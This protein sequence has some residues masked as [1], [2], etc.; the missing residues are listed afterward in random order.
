MCPAARLPIKS[1][2]FNRSKNPL[3]VHSLA[4][5]RLR[6]FFR[7]TKADRN[8]AILENN[9]IRAPLRFLQMPRHD[10]RYIQ[11]NRRSLSSQMKGNRLKFK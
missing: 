7:R 10:L 4:N 1:L 8:H 2:D 3:A 6:Q 9:F 11:V 5:A